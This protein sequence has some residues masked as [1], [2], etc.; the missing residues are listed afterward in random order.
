MSSQEA[1]TEDAER[2]NQEME[3]S[4]KQGVANEVLRVHGILDNLLVQPHLGDAQI[5]ELVRR[6][7]LPVRARNLD[8]EAYMMRMQAK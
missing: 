3:D 4:I 1:A 2:K 6:L 7:M 8:W 5:L